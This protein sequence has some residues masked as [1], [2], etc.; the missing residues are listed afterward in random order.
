MEE[1]TTNQ[2]ASLLVSK[3]KAS[4]MIQCQIDKERDMIEPI[5][6][7]LSEQ[8][9]EKHRDQYSKWS[10]VNTELLKRIFDN[11]FYANEYN[12]G[13]VLF[14]FARM[15]TL[16]DKYNDLQNYIKKEINKLESIHDR[17]ELIPQSPT[18]STNS[19]TTNKLQ[20]GKDIFIVHGH[21]NEAKREVDVFLR[22][23]DF[24]PII[25]HEQTNEGKTIIEKFENYSD[26]S[27]AII[28]LTPDDEGRV[29]N[30]DEELKPRARQNVILELGYFMGKLGRDKVCA[31]YKEKVEI[32]SDYSGI[33]Y[34]KM[35]NDSGW[36][37]KIAR[38]IKKSGL[39]VDLNKLY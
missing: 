32:P 39:D 24:N 1:N 33:L 12:Q 4:Q 14:G 15:P 9:L 27:F 37:M 38:E 36:H 5:P 2:N 35:D 16:W 7:F 11:Y 28:L 19:N 34:T 25:L 23:L 29:R 20:S 21:D 13:D 6:R 22:K 26:V 3:E 18:L 17:L 31:L 30:K 8:E 10:D